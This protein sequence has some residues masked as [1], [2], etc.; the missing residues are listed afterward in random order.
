VNGDNY[1]Y[2]YCCVNGSKTCFYSGAKSSVTHVVLVRV[3]RGALL[4]SLVLINWFGTRL[5]VTI[6]TPCKTS[7]RKSNCYILY[8][9]GKV[10]FP[11]VLLVQEMYIQATYYH[12]IYCTYHMN[13]SCTFPLIQDILVE[14]N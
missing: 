5:L 7:S 2:L 9:G 8:T 6:C 12:Q 11:I 14:L 3:Y 1:Y 13:F 10:E 4:L